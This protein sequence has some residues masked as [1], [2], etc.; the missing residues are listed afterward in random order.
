MLCLS[1]AITQVLR[2]EE[3]APSYS[4]PGTGSTEGGSTKGR[5]LTSTFKATDQHER[6]DRH[7]GVFE[8]RPPSESRGNSRSEAAT[9]RERDR[10]VARYALTATFTQ[11]IDPT[12]SH[13]TKYWDGG[14]G[15]SGMT[16]AT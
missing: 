2:A 14:N 15:S 12:N 9:K 6:T 10:E 1:R 8:A 13:A 5:G 3:R 16:K 4:T 7:Y 11:D